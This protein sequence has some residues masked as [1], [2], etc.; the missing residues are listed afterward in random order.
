MRELFLVARFCEGAL[1]R[2]TLENERGAIEGLTFAA[3][4]L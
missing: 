1:V 2:R 3:R 4:M